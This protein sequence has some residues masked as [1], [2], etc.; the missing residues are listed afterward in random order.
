MDLEKLHLLI[1]Y[2][3]LGAFLVCMTPAAY[4]FV[5][6]SECPPDRDQAA[7]TISSENAMP[8]VYAPGAIET[9]QGNQ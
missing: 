8:L 7:P 3:G 1:F 2:T 9:W 5:E 6:M 4:D